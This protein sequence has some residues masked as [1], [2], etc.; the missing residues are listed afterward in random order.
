MSSVVDGSGQNVQCTT[1]PQRTACTQSSFP[2]GISKMAYHPYL[3][4]EVSAIEAA[5]NHEKSLAGA[6][7]FGPVC[8]VF[9]DNKLVV[10]LL[11]GLSLFAWQNA[12]GINYYLPTLSKSTSVTE[13]H[14]SLLTTGV[15]ISSSSSMHSSGF[16]WLEAAYIAIAKHQLHPTT[17]L[18][19]GGKS[20][21]AF[22]YLW[23]V[24][25]SP[26]WK[27]TPWVLTTIFPDAELSPRPV[28]QLATGYT[29]SLLPASLH[30]WSTLFTAMGYGVYVF[31]ASFMVLSIAFVFLFVPESKQVLLER[32]EEIFTPGLPKDQGTVETFEK[33]SQASVYSDGNY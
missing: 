10:P 32:M 13:M 28:W 29:R 18:S 15:T 30:K 6:G 19:S 16:A 27:G 24:F 3:V 17:T 26:S 11:L 2:F 7:F 20:A 9:S 8:T 23:T 25:Y 4:E 31:F 1:H 12:T 5:V 21:I 33:A 14:A 22:F